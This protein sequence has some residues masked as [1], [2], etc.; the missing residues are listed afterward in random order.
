MQNDNKT[1]QGIEKFSVITVR[2]TLTKSKYLEP[3]IG[4]DNTIPSWDGTVFIYNKPGKIKK[5][6]IGKVDVQVKGTQ[7][8]NF[9]LKQAKYD[10]AVDDLKAYAESGGTIFFV[11]YIASDWQTKIYYNT[12]TPVKL[13]GLLK[14]CDGQEHKRIVLEEFPNGDREIANIFFHFHDSCKKQCGFTP[15]KMISFAELKNNKEITCITGFST[16]IDYPDGETAILNSETYLYVQKNNVPINIPVLASPLCLYINQDI[17]AT[18]SVNGAKFYDK[19]TI[20]KTRNGAKVLIGKSF[21]FPLDKPPVEVQW[22]LCPNFK[23]LLK[24]LDFMV[25]AIH[26]HGYEIDGNVI[27]L[28]LTKEEMAALDLPRNE[29]KLKLL[30]D[31]KLVFDKLHIKKDFNLSKL[32]DS[33]WRAIKVLITAFIDKLPVS[34]WQQKIEF[35]VI[36]QIQGIEILLAFKKVDDKVDTYEI[37]DFFHAPMVIISEGENGNYIVPPYAALTADEYSK[38]SNIDFED[39]V[40]SY[41]SLYEISEEQELIYCSVDNILRMI[42]AY[43]IKGNKCLL[44]VAMDIYNWLVEIGHDSVNMLLNKLQI[45]KRERDF[46]I[47]EKKVLVELAED[48]G[49]AEEVRVGANLLLDNQFAAKVHFEKMTKDDQELFKQF[50]IFKFW[51][52]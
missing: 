10:V 16:G 28:A 35:R 51:K 15:D 49:Q 23:D 5:H 31:I 42:E 26:N 19:I 27:E 4:D 17:P 13:Y 1:N 32:T 39:I 2:G 46:T 29:K 30:K 22:K 48:G 20:Q 43:D 52:G 50:P 25:S 41:K 21:S 24:D 34:G 14:E 6:F 7:Q 38:I 37:Y 40:P 12:L 18:I 44:K 36:F 33:E 45:I 8:D 3:Y 9:S 11:V 47:D